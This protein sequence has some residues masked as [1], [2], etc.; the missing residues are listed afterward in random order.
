MPKPAYNERIQWS[1]NCHDRP[2][3]G[4]DFGAIH[5]QQGDGTAASLANYLC[6]PNSEVSYHYTVDNNGNVVDVVDTDQASWSVGNANNRV[7]NVCFAGSYAEWTRDQWLRNMGRGIEIAAWLQV[8]DAFKYKFDPIVRGWDE[9]RRGMT[10][11]TDH[12]G[13][14]EGVLRASGHTDCGPNFPWDVYIGHVNRFVQEKRSPQAPADTRTDIEKCRDANTWLGAKT[15]EGRELA[16]PDGKGKRAVY[17]GGLIYW[18][19]DTKAWAIPNDLFA[20]YTELKWETGVLGYPV[21]NH[22]DLQEYTTSS[23]RVVAGG[24]VQAFSGG[25]I[26][27]RKG[28]PAIFHVRG[29]IRDHY[30]F[31]G[32]EHRL[33]WPIEDEKPWTSGKQRGAVQRF[34][35]GVIWWTGGKECIA[36]DNNGN[37]VGPE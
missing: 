21:A 1:P 33:G 5:T 31:V 24:R 25:T 30:R 6:N 16:N 7:I 22:L 12:R 36:F 17:A 29:L 26:Y 14:N 11:L 2:L 28:S 20:K 3:A 19:P 10:G 13:I 15:S 8:E 32:Y 34:E 23:K 4:I 35:A 9:L 27:A 18:H 37:P